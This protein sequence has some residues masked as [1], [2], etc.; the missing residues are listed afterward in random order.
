MVKQMSVL[1]SQLNAILRSISC[2]ETE[3]LPSIVESMALA[4]K[5]D[6]VL[7]SKV[8]RNRYKAETLAFHLDGQVAENFE[9][10]LCD[11]PC[12]EVVINPDHSCVYNSDV[13]LQFPNDKDLVKLGARSYFG[14]PLKDDDGELLG[15][16]V[17]LYRQEINDLKQLETIFG[18]F[19]GIIS[20]EL[21]IVEKNK[22]LALASSVIENAE[23]AVLVFNANR[24]IK[25]ANRAFE[26]ITGYLEKEVLNGVIADENLYPDP[27][28][29]IPRI[30]TAVLEHGS[31]QGELQSQRKDGEHYIQWL[32][33]NKDPHGFI[34]WQFSDISSKEN[35][36]KAIHFQANFDSLTLLPNRQLFED[37]LNQTIRSHKRYGNRFAVMFMDLDGFKSINDQY[38]HAVGD[39][40]LKQVA[41]RLKLR[42]RASDT[43]ARYGGDEFVFLLDPNCN[44][45]S[46]EVANSI[47]A[48]IAQPFKID[49]KGM[50]VS[51]SASIGV[52]YYPSNGNSAE[53]LVRNAD[54]AMYAAKKLGK[55]RYQ[56][57]PPP[58]QKAGNPKA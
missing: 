9:Y 38:G 11:T 43:V 54:T 33:V 5:A 45:S 52:S 1:D 28:R 16:F 17:A 18:L 6:A 25:F 42:L 12:E 34:I 23:E 26:K 48:V 50:T 10:S 57:F 31:W 46:E 22:H 4:T 51:V 15:I 47:C 32:Q 55:N 58:L 44:D 24:E 7:V 14:Y 19:S 30:M 2:S 36:S 20:R 39:Q 49:G 27:E 41:Q 13:Q 37:R 56:T 35:T 3:F 21:T 40:V 29:V 8:D 53:V